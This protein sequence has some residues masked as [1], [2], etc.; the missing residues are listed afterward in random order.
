MTSLVH[1][2]I[3]RLNKQLVKLSRRGDCANS[4]QAATRVCD[5]VRK[6]VGQHRPELVSALLQLGDVYAAQREYAAA[7]THFIEALE[8][9]E[10]LCGSSALSLVPTLQR[11]MQTEIALGNDQSV[12]VYRQRILD[13]QREP[14]LRSIVTDA[15]SA[16]SVGSAAIQSR[17]AAGSSMPEVSI[18]NEPV[19]PGPVSRRPAIGP[20]RRLRRA[21][22]QGLRLLLGRSTEKN[23][24][25]DWVDCCVFAPPTAAIGKTVVVQVFALL[26][27][28]ESIAERLA[29]E[30]DETATRRNRKSLETRIALESR[31]TFHLTIPSL[32]VDEPIQNLVWRG[33]PE[34]VVY[35]V[36]VPDQRPPG[37]VLGTVRV[38]IDTGPVG[39]IRFK[40]SIV[41]QRAAGEIAAVEQVG[42]QSRR[43]RRAFISYASN[44]RPEVL[45]RVGMLRIHHI[46]FFQ[47][48]LNIEPGE[49]WEKRLY[50]EID[51]CDLFLL[52]W[53]RAAESS[54]WVA[55]EVEYALGRRSRDAGELP[56]ILPV[57]I[58][59]PPLVQPPKQLQHMHFNDPLLY[60]APKQS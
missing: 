34:S 19:P 6:Y 31:L 17:S 16:S 43:Y 26:A 51:R 22:R 55:K 33:R 7:R 41:N 29:R 47:D 18:D 59:V 11:L 20:F 46:Q 36:H 35:A 57:P 25:G 27:D 58:E 40:L 24:Q 42:D 3:D 30:F 5:L 10:E 54:P 39:H 13:I 50:A 2:E 12:A 48:L 23:S 4:V 21:L 38:S 37:D 45:K 28:Q 8:I 60:L 15:V 32:E 44:D 56:E 53:S 14:A 9:Q 52:F 49:H 1:K